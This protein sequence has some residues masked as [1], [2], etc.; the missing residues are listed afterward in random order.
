MESSLLRR[1]FTA[2]LKDGYDEG[3]GQWVASTLELQ[4]ASFGVCQ[5]CRSF[6]TLKV[7]VCKE[8]PISLRHAVHSNDSGVRHVPVVRPAWLVWEFLVATLLTEIKGERW[9]KLEALCLHTV[10][11]I[12]TME[13]AVWPVSLKKFTVGDKFNQPIVGVVWPASLQQLAFGHS[14]NQPI[15]GIVWPAGLQKLSFGYRFNQYIVNVA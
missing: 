7:R 6:S 4:L 2:V 8:T 5:V 15:T 9:G 3:T 13:G 1:A 12:G 11:P 10:R 14:F